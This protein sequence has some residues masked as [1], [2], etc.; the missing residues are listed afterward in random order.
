MV[1][2]LQFTGYNRSPSLG[3]GVIC[4]RVHDEGKISVFID[5]LN[6]WVNSGIKTDL[7]KASLSNLEAYFW[8]TR[9]FANFNFFN[10]LFQNS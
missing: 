6:K 1:I 5:S 8:D 10:H 9:G 2:G 7:E 4:P 3:I